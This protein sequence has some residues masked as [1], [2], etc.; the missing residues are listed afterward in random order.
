MDDQSSPVYEFD[1]DFEIDEHGHQIVHDEEAAGYRGQEDRLLEHSASAAEL[2]SYPDAGADISADDF[3]DAEPNSEG[4]QL[5][6]QRRSQH[7]N[8]QAYHSQ[9]QQSQNP[10][11]SAPSSVGAASS[12]RSFLQDVDLD[13]DAEAAL[14]DDYLQ[15]AQKSQAEYSRMMPQPEARESNN[16]TAPKANV[17]TANELS[18]ALP[19]PE[20]QQQ[21]QLAHRRDSADYEVSQVTALMDFDSGE[22]VEYDPAAALAE[23]AARAEALAMAEEDGEL[24]DVNAKHEPPEADYDPIE[25]HDQVNNALESTPVYSGT[26]VYSQYPQQQKLQQQKKPVIAKDRRT[27]KAATGS[28]QP[29]AKALPSVP[30]TPPKQSSRPQSSSQP[31]QQQQQQPQPSRARIPRSSSSTASGDGASVTAAG[32]AT[33][34]SLAAS[35]SQDDLQLKQRLRREETIRQQQETNK[36]ARRGGPGAGGRGFDPRLLGGGALIGGKKGQ[37]LR[38]IQALHKRLDGA[39]LASLP[40]EEQEQLRSELRQAFDQLQKEFANRIVGEAGDDDGDEEDD[41][42]GG[43]DVEQLEGELFQLSMRLDELDEQVTENARQSGQKRRTPFR[44]PTFADRRRS[45]LAAVQQSTAT[46]ATATDIDELVSSAE[47]IQQC[48]RRCFWWRRRSGSAGFAVVCGTTTAASSSGASRRDLDRLVGELRRIVAESA[49][50]SRLIGTADQLEA[51]LAALAAAGGAVGSPRDGASRR[52]PGIPGN[53]ADNSPAKSSMVGQLGGGGGGGALSENDSGFA[54]SAGGGHRRRS[55]QQQQQLQLLQRRQ[56]G[57][58]LDEMLS[59]RVS[60]TSSTAQSRRLSRNTDTDVAS[61]PASASQQQQLQRRSSRNKDQTVDRDYQDLEQDIRWLRDQLDTEIEAEAAAAA[62]AA[63]GATPDDAASLL[64]SENN[65]RSSSTGKRQPSQQSEH[66]EQPEQPPATSRKSDEP[67]RRQT[68]SNSRPRQPPFTVEYDREGRPVR[69]Y[70]LEDDFYGYSDDDERVGQDVGRDRHND[71]VF[72]DDN[73]QQSRR[74]S[75]G[76]RSGV[77][78]DVNGHRTPSNGVPSAGILRQ[79]RRHPDYDDD[80]D[81]DDTE[82]DLYNSGEFEED[83]SDWPEFEYSEYSFYPKRHPR[84]ASPRAAG[85]RFR[86]GDA[87]GGG[88]ES[89][90]RPSRGWRKVPERRNRGR[91]VSFENRVCSGCGAEPGTPHRRSGCLTAAGHPAGRPPA[92]PHQQQHQNAPSGRYPYR[93]TGPLGSAR[94]RVY[95]VEPPQTLRRYIVTETGPADFSNLRRVASVSSLASGNGRRPRQ[96]PFRGKPT[97]SQQQQEFYIYEADSG[98]SVGGFQSDHSRTQSQLDLSD[99]VKAAKMLHK[100]SS[101]LH[102][103]LKRDIMHRSS[104]SSI[105]LMGVY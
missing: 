68:A 51:E 64:S 37:L 99:A 90:G 83:D 4:R 93:K 81:L 71:G 21:L 67:H 96:M 103:H 79:G 18:R 39:N 27:R 61:V 98:A 73:R 47:A 29:A 59:G 54:T 38:K 16:S 20:Q 8:G 58:P 43:V 41:E 84:D 30:A 104:G 17:S 100:L 13:D 23:A 91:P 14:L 34:A 19:S 80:N 6:G 11:T 46:A 2:W 3:D 89:V 63:A 94:E 53:A 42:F 69:R 57:S 12:S 60:A 86:G 97:G 82:E 50:R 40:V 36:L 77:G 35:G 75:R 24:I 65:R 66:S 10:W 45:S 28:K 88:G 32:A 1:L 25:L 70:P 5:R 76:S 15:E 102:R 55:S 78:Q 62:A 95:N 33:S 72:Y 7:R 101:R 56:R 85:M 9:Q 87:G 74:R 22:M 52:M 48:D 92:Y 44:D 49:G 26:T 31:P 105:N